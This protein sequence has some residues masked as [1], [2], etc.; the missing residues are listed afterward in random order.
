MFPFLS[1]GVWRKRRQR[2]E[3]TLVYLHQFCCDGAGYVDF[4]PHYFFNATKLSW[5][6]LKV[7]PC[8]PP[9]PPHSSPSSRGPGNPPPNHTW[10]CVDLRNPRP[11]GTPH[12]KNNGQEIG[13]T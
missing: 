4:K 10:L 11:S 9:A 1:G 13:K 3:Y 6:H 2:H 12:N 8:D 7:Q 5:L